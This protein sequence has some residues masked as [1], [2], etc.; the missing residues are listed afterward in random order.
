MNTGAASAPMSGPAAGW[1]PAARQVRSPNCDAR[2][3][4]CAI[5]LIVIHAISLPPAEFG[6]PY[7][8]QLFTNTLDTGAHAYFAQLRGLRVSAHFLLTRVAQLTQFVDIHQRAWHAGESHWEGRA[9][10]NDF[11]IGIELE[12]CDDMPFTA[13]QYA[14]LTELLATLMHLLPALTPARIV[15][16]SD[17]APRRKTDPGPHF[18]WA[19]VR[20]SVAR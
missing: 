12:G 4:G 2:P 16:H 9:R 8:E 14:A 1:L 19:R 20:R 15:G 6:G 5:D 18:D 7:V 17:I 3:A 13:V 11:S 10:C